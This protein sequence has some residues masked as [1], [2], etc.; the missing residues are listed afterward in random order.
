VWPDTAL[1]GWSDHPVKL[2]LVVKLL[3]DRSADIEPRD[4]DGRT[5]LDTALAGCQEGL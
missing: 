3:L 2:F 1:M 5:V 4:G